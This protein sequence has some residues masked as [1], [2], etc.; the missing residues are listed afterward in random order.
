MSGCDAVL[1]GAKGPGQDP[2]Q[3]RLDQ[4]GQA[5]GFPKND[6]IHLPLE[7]VLDDG[8]YRQRERM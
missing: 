1:A 5:P 4:I 2:D 7:T 8:W 3:D 6:L